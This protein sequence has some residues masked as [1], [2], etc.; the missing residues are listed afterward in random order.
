M[1]FNLQNFYS[2]TSSSYHQ[3]NDFSHI[4]HS[5]KLLH[6][7][8]DPL[9]DNCSGKTSLKTSLPYSFQSLVSA[10]T[11]PSTMVAFCNFR[12]AY[13]CVRCEKPDSDLCQNRCCVF[14]SSLLEQILLVW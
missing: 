13:G 3:L 9:R 6:R 10:L 7:L 14:V 5:Q 1:H 4:S 11:W 2:V 12:N 8:S